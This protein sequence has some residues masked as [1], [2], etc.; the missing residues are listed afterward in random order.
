MVN[1]THHRGSADMSIIQYSYV[2][3]WQGGRDCMGTT[4]K[5]TPCT[6]VVRGA[7]L[8]EK[9]VVLCKHHLH[10]YDAVVEATREAYEQRVAE[11]RARLRKE[12]PGL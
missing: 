2:G 4:R 9:R 5:G 7:N 6:R 11:R 10:Q 1:E 12:F 3:G 8:D